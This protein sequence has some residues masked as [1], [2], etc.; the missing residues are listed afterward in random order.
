[1]DKITEFLFGLILGVCITVSITS[2]LF[3]ADVSF[4]H[5][6]ERLTRTKTAINILIESPGDSI[7]VTSNKEPYPLGVLKFEANK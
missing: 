7:I 4:W 1:M 6:N 2:I 5:D 3:S